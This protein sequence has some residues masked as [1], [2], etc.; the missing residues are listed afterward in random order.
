MTDAAPLEAPGADQWRRLSTRM[1]LVHPVKEFIRFLPAVAGLLI[2]GST[3]NGGQWW[4]GLIGAGLAIGLGLLRWFTTRYRFTADQVQ[5][6]HG[7][8]SRSTVT[9]PID[10]VRTVDVTSSVLHRVLGLAEVKIGTGADDKELA[11]DGLTTQ[12]AGAL[13]HELLHRRRGVADGATPEGAVPGDESVDLP[14]GFADEE[15]ILRLDPRWIRFAPFGPSGL[16]AAAAIIGVSLQVINEAGFNPDE[17]STVQNGIDQAERI[18]VWVAVLILVIGAALLVLLLSLGGYLLLYWGFRLTRHTRG[19]TLHVARGL[20]TTRATTLE[21]R[22]IRGVE[23]QEP[24]ALR[25]VG[26]ARLAAITTGLKGSDDRAQSSM[27]VPPAPVAVA[28]GVADRVLGVPGTTEVAL[29]RHGPAAVRRRYSRALLGGAVLAVA[30]GVAGFL[31]TPWLAVVAVV[32]LA[33]SALLAGDRAR[34]LGHALT[35]QHV[36]SRSGS[37]L[38]GTDVIGRSG[39]IGVSLRRSYFQRRAGLTTVTM[40]TAAGDQRYDVMDVT[41][42]VAT[43]LADDLLPTHLAPFTNSP[44]E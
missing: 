8:F 19:G 39:V 4:W 26:G 25:L 2:A 9:A 10:R 42:P 23:L 16:I 38:R 24:L 5:L 20:L 43:A 13:R 29:R 36:V 22:R 41:Q 7:L 18:G 27:L 35:E 30:A 11:L 6:R 17:N 32:P 44:V 12:Q 40:A 34:S 21:T 33:A 31:V 1:L 15:E 3:S 28:R 37:L 14:T